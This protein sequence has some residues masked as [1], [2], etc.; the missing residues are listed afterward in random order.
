MFLGN[1]YTYLIL[2]IHDSQQAKDTF[3]IFHIF[4]YKVLCPEYIYGGETMVT[5]LEYHQ[6]DNVDNIR[7]LFEL[8]KLAD[9]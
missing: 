1:V 5:V 3:P 7:T 8:L 4:K 9:M 2:D 6:L